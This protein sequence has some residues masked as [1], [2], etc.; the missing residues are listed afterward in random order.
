[1]GETKCPGTVSILLISMPM[2][3]TVVYVAMVPTESFAT[4]VPN[5]CALSQL[6]CQLL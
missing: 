5:F 1:M 2:V 4:M 6:G 3:E